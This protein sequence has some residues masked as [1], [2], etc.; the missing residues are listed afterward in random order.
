MELLNQG[1]FFC[2]ICTYFFFKLLAIE[3]KMVHF[4]FLE[5]LS[6]VYLMSIVLQKSIS[7]RHAVLVFLFLFPFCYNF[8]W[9]V[10]LFFVPSFNACKVIHTGFFTLYSILYYQLGGALRTRQTSS[11]FAI[12]LIVLGLLLVNFEVVAMNNHYQAIYDGVNSSFPTIGALAMSIG[13]FFLLKDFSFNDG[14]PHLII[15]YVGRNT[16]GIFIFHVMGIILLRKYFPDALFNI[17]PIIA[18]LISLLIVLIT[19]SFSELLKKL[20]LRFLVSLSC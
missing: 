8:L 16:M 12:G 20:H 18:L 7:L 6:I 13:I 3:D 1:I 11:F 2:L 4:W 10:V 9:D 17:N 15:S 19:A 5:T 14:I